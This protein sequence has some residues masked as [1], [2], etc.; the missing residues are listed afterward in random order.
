[1]SDPSHEKGHTLNLVLSY[2]LDVCIMEIKHCGISDHFP[3][4]FNIA[5]C[6][7]ELNSEGPECEL[8]MINLLT[9][10]HFPS[11]FTNSVLFD[12]NLSAELA[13]L[14]ILCDCLSK[15]Q[16]KSCKICIS[17]QRNF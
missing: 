10:A 3:V 16:K 15:Y 14:G 6:N 1:M 2:G 11:A 13:S 4:T 9:A 8:H 7:A 12:A 17:V 5:V